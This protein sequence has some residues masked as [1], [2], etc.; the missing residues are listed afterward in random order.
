MSSAKQILNW[1]SIRRWGKQFM[2]VVTALAV[3]LGVL[4][5]L[6]W[7]PFNRS[8]GSSDA[9]F[10]GMNNG[11]IERVYG[12]VQQNFYNGSIA[13]P[14]P[15]SSPPVSPA[16]AVSPPT[17]VAKPQQTVSA[18]PG[19]SSSTPTPFDLD[20]SLSEGLKKVLRAVPSHFRDFRGTESKDETHVFKG[21]FLF[22]GASFADCRI[23]NYEDERGF[24]SVTYYYYSYT[25]YYDPS[26]KEDSRQKMND[27]HQRLSRIFSAYKESGEILTETGS[28]VEWDSPTGHLTRTY[29]PYIKLRTNAV[30]GGLEYQ[31]S[32]AVTMLGK[33]D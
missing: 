30:P 22:A 14:S 23:Q 28:Y 4:E 3:I 9:S 24:I 11:S 18:T 29:E 13:I 16:I 25:I 10:A 27:L 31:V 6:Q 8:K 12:P 26:S 32:L 7:W 5:K 2:V 17:L 20:T 21:S 1:A 19:S 15:Q 33:A